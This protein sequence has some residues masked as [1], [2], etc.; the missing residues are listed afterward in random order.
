LIPTG[1]PKLE[2][3]LFPEFTSAHSLIS[4]VAASILEKG[5]GNVAFYDDT[6]VM[7]GLPPKSFNN[8]GKPPKKRPK[9][10][11]W[12]VSTI[13]LPATWALNKEKNWG[14]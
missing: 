14:F 8:F 6:N 12:E 3:P 2:S 11:C 9:A 5:Y 7:F 4:A 10:D 1:Y 13:P